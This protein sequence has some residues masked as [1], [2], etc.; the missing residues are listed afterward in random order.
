MKG[1]KEDSTNK[2]KGNKFNINKSI[3]KINKTINYPK[4]IKFNFRFVK[5]NMI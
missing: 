1:E 5:L 2:S 4:K 3:S